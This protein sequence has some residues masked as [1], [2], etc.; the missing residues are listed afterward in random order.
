MGHIDE[1]GLDLALELLYD[2]SRDELRRL[3]WE[4]LLISDGPA[5]IEGEVWGP[6][7]ARYNTGSINAFFT[8]WN[9]KEDPS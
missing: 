6:V 7:Q 1:P 9:P 5:K 8:V 4:A 3:A 2:L